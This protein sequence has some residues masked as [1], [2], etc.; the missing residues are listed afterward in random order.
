M[1]DFGAS[2][3]TWIGCTD[4][5]GVGGSPTVFAVRWNVSITAYGWGGGSPV[6]IGRAE[7]VGSAVLTMVSASDPATLTLAFTFSWVTAQAQ[8]PAETATAGALRSS[9]SRAAEKSRIQ[10]GSTPVSVHSLFLKPLDRESIP[11]MNGIDRPPASGSPAHSDQD[12]C[13]M[14]ASTTTRFQSGGS[15][16]QKETTRH[17]RDPAVIA[18]FLLKLANG[19]DDRHACICCRPGLRLTVRGGTQTDRAQRD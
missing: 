6:G 14:R 10:P 13:R 12:S 9:P 4:Q 5:I 11:A 1:N 8:A 3:L 19:H 15:A 17:G 2:E 7:W 18:G 16:L